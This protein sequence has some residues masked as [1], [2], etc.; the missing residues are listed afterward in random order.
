MLAAG[1]VRL[2]VADQGPLLLAAATAAAATWMCA[3][4]AQQGAVTRRLPFACLVAYQFAASANHVLPTGVGAGAV[5]LRFLMRC[6]M[7][8]ARSATA[9]AVKATA[10]GVARGALIAVLATAC[11]GVLRPP[12][13][14]GLSGAFMAWRWPP[15]RARSWWTVRCGPGSAGP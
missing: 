15:R 7:P 14:S 13:V 12:R 11:P 10:G 9:L 3:A 8:A 2:A 5:N 4:P 1:A 6:G